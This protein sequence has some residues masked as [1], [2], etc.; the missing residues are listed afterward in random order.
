[1]KKLIL[2]SAVFAAFAG[3]YAHAEQAPATEHAVTYNMG[4]TSDYVFRGISQSR[5]KPAFSA[6]ADYTH[7][8]TGFYAGTWASTISWISDSTPAGTRANTP[9]EID[10][11]GGKR[12]EVSGVSYDV[13]GIYYYYPN[14]KLG[15][16]PDANTFEAYGQVGMGPVYFKANYALT[17]AFFTSNKAGSYYLDAGAN[18]P[19]AEGFVLNLHYGYFSFKD[20][21]DYN[22]KDWKVGIT[23]DFGGL[24]VALAAT[25]TDADKGLWNF[26]NTGYLGGSKFIATVTKSF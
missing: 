11:Y 3:S 13:G 12:G 21:K 23:K 19:I 1:M 17:D 20:A 6:G 2:A 25:G 9:F 15:S 8:P 10:F 7:T 14:H 16:A 4:V 5:N 22:Y 18:V 24:A 26:N